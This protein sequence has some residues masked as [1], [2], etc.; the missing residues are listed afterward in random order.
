CPE[1]PVDDP[2]SVHRLRPARLTLYRA[3]ALNAGL[4]RGAVALLA[5][6]ATPAGS[7]WLRHRRRVRPDG[8]RAFRGVVLAMRQSHP[9]GDPESEGR[10]NYAE[11]HRFRRA[12]LEQPP[13]E[14]PPEAVEDGGPANIDAGD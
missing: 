12:E 6:S 9:E 3:P 14:H 1:Q 11:P 10:C 8:P 4:P 7:G 2:A 13:G 5:L